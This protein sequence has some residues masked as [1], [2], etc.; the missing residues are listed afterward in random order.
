MIEVGE[1]GC[2]GPLVKRE[3]NIAVVYINREARR[4]SISARTIVELGAV[5]DELAADDSVGAVVVAGAG[6]RA[7][8]AG[9]DLEEGFDLDAD[10]R[11]FVRAG[12]LVYQKI[13]SFPKPVVAAV[14]GY[15]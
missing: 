3:D 5:F 6:G 10:V 12:Q 4:N 14:E 9:A 15:A 2:P 8:S 7:F 13:E 11:G 1:C